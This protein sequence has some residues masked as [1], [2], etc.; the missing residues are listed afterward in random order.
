MGVLNAAD[1]QTVRVRFENGICFLQMYRP[2]AGNTIN[3]RLVQECADVVRFAEEHATILVLEGL[4][5]VFCWGADFGELAAGDGEAG[6]GN[7]PRPPCTTC[8]SHWPS[9]RSSPWRTCAARSTPEDWGSWPR[10]T[11]CCARTR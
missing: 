11:S 3:A 6:T 4:P 8:G 5:E 10:A 1:Y 2:E 9:D 7:R